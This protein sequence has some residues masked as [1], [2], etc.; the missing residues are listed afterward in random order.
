MGAVWIHS[1]GANGFGALALK[2]MGMGQGVKSLHRKDHPDILFV[3]ES[4]SNDQHMTVHIPN[5]PV[6]L[7][8]THSV[9]GFKSKYR[10]STIPIDESWFTDADKRIQALSPSFNIL[11]MSGNYDWGMGYDTS[12]NNQEYQEC[13]AQANRI[14]SFIRRQYNLWRKRSVNTTYCL[15]QGS[16]ALE[17]L[18]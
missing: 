16:V 11:L 3:F 8:I 13:V 12:R 18:V 9:M 4:I 6:L 14:R 5:T 15:K 7:H 2:G 10:W 17:P 1:V